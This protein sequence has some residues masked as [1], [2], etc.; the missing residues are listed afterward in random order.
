MADTPAKYQASALIVLCFVAFAVMSGP[1]DIFY[2]RTF[3]LLAGAGLA[4]QKSGRLGALKG[5]PDSIN[6][7]IVKTASA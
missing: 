5:H 7:L 3:W 2:Q 6:P 1:G 4:L